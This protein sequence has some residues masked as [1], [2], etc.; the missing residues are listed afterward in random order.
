M[1]FLSSP[2]GNSMCGHGHQ[3]QEAN[4][5]RHCDS[6]LPRIDGLMKA[7]FSA[8]LA[9]KCRGI[10][11][12]QREEC[13]QEDDAETCHNAQ[14]FGVL[15]AQRR[16][17]VVVKV[18]VKTTMMTNHNEG[19]VADKPREKERSKNKKKTKKKTK[20]D[21]CRNDSNDKSCNCDFWCWALHVHADDTCN[22]RISALI[23][24][25]IRIN[26]TATGDKRIQYGVGRGCM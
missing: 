15:L 3:Q 23:L 18:N 13:Y 6:S 4:H 21:G 8:L 11:R 26:R 24:I 2:Y 10:R 19:V 16:Q 25:T 9:Q 5:L 7:R 22:C 20:N 14:K 12:R 17:E 1:L